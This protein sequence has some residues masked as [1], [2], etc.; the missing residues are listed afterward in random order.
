MEITSDN[1]EM[2]KAVEHHIISMLLKHGFDVYVPIIDK[3]TDLI[4]KDENGGFIE[5]QVKSRR[6]NCDDDCFF[7]KDFEVRRNFL[8]ICH[9]WN[10]D[11]FFVIPS[12]IFHRH[13]KLQENKTYRELTYSKLKSKGCQ[14]EK[15][16]DFLRKALESKSNRV[17]LF[18]D[19]EDE[20]EVNA[21]IS[22][23]KNETQNC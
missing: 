10:E 21:Y 1:T 12:L 11:K 9:N 7:I 17:K 23:I 4:V 16:L 3:G 2:G 14:E 15:G 20:E 19:E 13:S 6:I 8:I 18:L 22:S 5:I